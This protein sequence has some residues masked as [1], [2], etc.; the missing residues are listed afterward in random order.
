[1]DYPDYPDY[2][3]TSDG[4]HY[5]YRIEDGA[6]GGSPVPDYPP[7]SLAFEGGY[8]PAN[9]AKTAWSA[10]RSGSKKSP[11]GIGSSSTPRRVTGRMLPA[12]RED[13][14]LRLLLTQADSWDRLNA[15]E[16]QVL[17]ALPTPHGPL[18]VWLESQLHEHGPQP[19]AALREGLRGHANERHAVMQINQMMDGVQPDWNEVR[20]ILTQLLTLK[21][22]AEITELA[23]RAHEDPA[24]MQR[25][26]EL[27]AQATKK[28]SA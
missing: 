9:P 11:S 24:A 22:D 23:A 17:L 10:G 25:L 4:T 21:R 7:S 16:H 1:L 27:M 15:Q 28:S 14:V 18:F 19:W 26:R 20:S 2:P 13:R 8:A 12:S 3:D 6:N 5:T